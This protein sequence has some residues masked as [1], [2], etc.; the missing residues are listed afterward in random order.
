MAALLMYFIRF[1]YDYA[2]SDQDETI[3]YLLHRLDPSLFAQ[4]W[5]VQMQTAEIGI[6]TFFVA[7]LHFLSLVL[8]VWLA[9]LVVYIAAFLILAGAVYRL[10]VLLTHDILVAAACLVAV[11]VLTPQ[12]TLGGN[13]LVHAMLVPSMV[14][15]GLAL[16][17][18]VYYLQQRLLVSALL[19]GLATWTQVLVGLQLAGLL[20]VVLITEIFR[21]ER[22]WADI[23]RFGG[24]FLLTSL[25]ALVPILFQQIGTPER[26]EVADAPSVFYL[27]AAFRAPHHYLFHS[28]PLRTVVRFGALALLGTASLAW[29]RHSRPQFSYRFIYTTLVSILCLCVFGYL[30]TEVWPVLF[31]AKL[32]LFKTTVFAKIL[33]VLLICA[34]AMT[35]LP[36][37]LRNHLK[38]ILLARRTGFITVC[39]VGVLLIGIALWTHGPLHSKIRPLA[40]SDTEI[41]ELE[42]WVQAQTPVDAVF[43]VPPSWSGFRSR[44]QRAAVVTFK[45]FPFED[46]AI[47]E[48]YQRLTD[49][50]PLEMPERGSPQLQAGLDGAFETLSSN[51]FRTLGQRYGFKYV[52]RSQPL[53]DT[54]VAEPIYTAGDWTVYRM[55]FEARFANLALHSVLR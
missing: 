24:V 37:S 50:A 33:F 7:L 11:L 44:A 43:A 48:W 38:S 12:W 42:S 20:G 35:S 25:P 54:Q 8:P 13:D 27:M 40:H 9:V 32:Q 10:G 41:A 46:A 26:P 39:I 22:Q 55:S 16:W 2:N 36:V 31:I 29:L 15:W 52:I 3:P 17:G 51:Q 23:F 53:T 47:H 49:I 34:T 21:A 1:G 18:V 5:F 28:F 30:F 6:R 14:A 45:N 19:L 4:D